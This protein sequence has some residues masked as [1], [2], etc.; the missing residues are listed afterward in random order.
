MP[1]L[2]VLGDKV[3]VRSVLADSAAYNCGSRYT[4][5]FG[6][7]IVGNRSEHRSLSVDSFLVVAVYV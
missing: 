1:Q 5:A 2:T 3:W 4:A 7:Y 6:G